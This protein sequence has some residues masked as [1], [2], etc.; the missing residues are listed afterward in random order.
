M[1]IKTWATLSGDFYKEQALC[2]DL[3]SCVKCYKIQG[4]MGHYMPTL[5]VAKADLIS[6]HLS[7][8]TG[9]GIWKDW[10]VA[11]YE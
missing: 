7:Q 5:V 9:M 3:V 10:L 8:A 1:D 4:A 2:E 6:L 11:R